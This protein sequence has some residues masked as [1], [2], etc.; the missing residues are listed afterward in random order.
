MAAL[1][2]DLGKP[3]TA[4]E[5]P[6]KGR[7]FFGNAEKSEEIARKIVNRLKL[8]TDEKRDIL[9]LVKNHDRLDNTMSDKS[10]RKAIDELGR[11]TVKDLIKI[12]KADRL[13]QA[14]L[15]KA[16][17]EE[18]ISELKD[19]YKKNEPITYGKKDLKITGKELVSDFGMKPG[20]EIGQTLELM[21]KSVITN[22]KLNTEKELK[23]YIPKKYR[24]KDEKA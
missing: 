10:M 13:A 8:S 20:K 14:R 21:H 22:P 11:D 19:V 4:I 1:F 3:D 9:T 24:V 23:Q 16:E 2:H 5:H 7:Q 17:V 15:P 18:Q 12:K 6:T